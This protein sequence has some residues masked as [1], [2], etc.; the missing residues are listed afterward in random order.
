MPVL[1]IQRILNVLFA[2]TQLSQGYL[3]N[4][5]TGPIRAVVRIIDRAIGRNML[6]PMNSYSQRKALQKISGRLGVFFDDDN[7]RLSRLIGM[8]LSDLGYS[9]NEQAV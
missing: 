7:A 2:R 3:I 6:R 9:V 4:I 1:H 8:R 5:G